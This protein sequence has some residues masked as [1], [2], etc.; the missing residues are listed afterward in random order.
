M[1]AAVLTSSRHNTL[2][3]H[4]NLLIVN[5]GVASQGRCRRFARIACMRILLAA[6]TA[7]SLTTAASASPVGLWRAN[8]GAEIRIAACGAALCGQV[9]KARID[10]ATG[11][12]AHDRRGRPLTGLQILTGMR[13]DGPGKWSGQLYNEDDGNVYPGHLLELGPA[14]IRIEGCALGI[15]GGGELSR[16]K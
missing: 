1:Q 13:A 16:V 14:R 10:P 12:P 15:C 3:W 2:A 5:S 7:L 4:S 6:V 8:D 9:A 11:K